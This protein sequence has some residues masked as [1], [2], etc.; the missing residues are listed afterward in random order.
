MADVRSA[1]AQ[2]V[3]QD[4][5]HEVGLKAK[6]PPAVIPNQEPE[7][8]SD[9]SGHFD[10]R[11]RVIYETKAARRSEEQTIHIRRADGGWVIDSL[12]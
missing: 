9:G 12:D 6:E 8:S 11:I 2:H 3:E 4:P 7:C 10:C 5:V 1:Y